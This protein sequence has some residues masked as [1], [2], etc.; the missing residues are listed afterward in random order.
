MAYLLG[1]NGLN[2]IAKTSFQAAVVDMVADNGRGRR[3]VRKGNG[4]EIV[5][6]QIAR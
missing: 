2:A 1:D 3:R 5:L 6:E 4:N